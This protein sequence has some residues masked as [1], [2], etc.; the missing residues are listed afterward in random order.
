M[1]PW[2]TFAAGLTFGIL[3]GGIVVG[4]AMQTKHEED[5]AWLNHVFTEMSRHYVECVEER[6]LR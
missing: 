4:Q 6:D 3:V 1:T 2:R 5:M